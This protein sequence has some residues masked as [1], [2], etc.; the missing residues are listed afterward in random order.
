LQKTTIYLPL[1]PVKPTAAEGDQIMVRTIS[2]DELKA[3]L[4]RGDAVVILEAL[5]E[6]HYGHSHLP[7]AI[8]FP[9]DQ[10]E[11]LAPRIVPDKNADIVV[12]CANAACKNSGIAAEALRS[13]G[14]A[15]VRAYEAGKADWIDAGYPI[16]GTVARH[17]A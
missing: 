17:A 16:E 1:R 12:Y 8:N 4:D 10:V 11:A 13:L 5:P 14:Y 6:K 15:N 7:G 3:K 2:R 9:H